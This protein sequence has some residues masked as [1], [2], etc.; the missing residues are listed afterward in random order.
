MELL[1]IISVAFGFIGSVLL[2][3]GLIKSH[4]QIDDETATY[5][6]GNPFTKENLLSEQRLIF[7]GFIFI[8]AGFSFQ[9]STEITFYPKSSI[10][11][12]SILTGLLLTVTG[13]LALFIFIQARANNHEK[14]R[15][16]HYTG[17]L[18]NFLQ[19]CKEEISGKN[20]KEHPEMIRDWIKSRMGR[21][22]E[23]KG[24]I[25]DSLWESLLEKFII[26]IEQ[27]SSPNSDI[28]SQYITDFLNK[29]FFENKK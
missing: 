17:V 7:T 28:I 12:N 21:F 19:S 13:V 14:R 5:W 3:A 20:Y 15:R 8:I 2:S 6:G 16:S 9:L 27:E 18:K 23:F 4:K 26:K 29:H 1:K 22:R 11:F 25:N 24:D 10:L